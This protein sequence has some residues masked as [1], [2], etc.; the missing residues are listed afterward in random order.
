[1]NIPKEL[2]PRLATLFYPDKSHTENE[3]WQLNNG[4]AITYLVSM[5]KILQESSQKMFSRLKVGRA[6]SHDSRGKVP[7]HNHNDRRTTVQMVL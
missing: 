2:L 7:V 6:Q 4:R 1:M 3:Q 5:Q